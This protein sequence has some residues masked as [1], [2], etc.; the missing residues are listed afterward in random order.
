MVVDGCN[1]GWAFTNNVR[2][3]AEGLKEVY[4]CFKRKGYQD[5]EI[6]IIYKH[7]PGKFLSDNDVAIIEFLEKINILV[8]R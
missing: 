3:S 7:I 1:V 8:T 2:F 5:N 4:E 6:S